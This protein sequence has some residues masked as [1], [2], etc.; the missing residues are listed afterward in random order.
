MCM[1]AGLILDAR[2]RQGQGAP[3]ARRKNALETLLGAED[4][5]GNTVRPGGGACYGCAMLSFVCLRTPG[6][7]TT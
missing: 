6:R 4:E 2:A 7:A 1:H 3:L 5:D